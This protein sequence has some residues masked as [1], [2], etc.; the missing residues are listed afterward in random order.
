MEAHT[1]G[2]EGPKQTEEEIPTN[3]NQEETQAGTKRGRENSRDGKEDREASE[4]APEK[5]LKGGGG[6]SISSRRKVAVGLL[7]ERAEEAVRY[8]GVLQSWGKM[9]F[10]RARRWEESR[11][12]GSRKTL[13]G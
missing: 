2:R 12:L 6:K 9:V 4:E 1:G 13:T 5:F 7:L 3:G 11:K 8:S 10:P